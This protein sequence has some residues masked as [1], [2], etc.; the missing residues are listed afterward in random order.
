MQ[1]GNFW[2]QL[3]AVNELRKAVWR[4]IFWANPIGSK[5]YIRI[6]ISI[7]RVLLEYTKVVE[8]TERI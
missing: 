3:F 1:K 7:K 5:I 4:I 2:L 6:N 8:T